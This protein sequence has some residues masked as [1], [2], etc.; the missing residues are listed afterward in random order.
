MTELIRGGEMRR[1]IEQTALW[2][3]KH[4]AFTTGFLRGFN[5]TM[6]R[7]G[8]GIYEVVTFPFPSYEPLLVPK[9][10]LYPDQS[11]R[12]RSYPFGG[13]DL[14]EHPV[15]PS[16]YEPGLISDSMFDTDTSLGFSSGDVA[17]MVPGSRFR[18][19]DH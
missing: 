15:Y 1:S 7:T 2:E 10:P 5:R 13:L 14:P 12:T 4:T 6:A 11:I 19:F 9:N 3:S 17:P 8:I 18:I 16:N